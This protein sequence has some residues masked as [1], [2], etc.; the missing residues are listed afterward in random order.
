MLTFLKINLVSSH[1]EVNINWLPPLLTPIK[2]NRRLATNPTIDFFSPETF[3]V[4]GAPF[5][6]DRGGNTINHL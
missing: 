1:T 5:Y 2:A 3:K 4:D 6:S